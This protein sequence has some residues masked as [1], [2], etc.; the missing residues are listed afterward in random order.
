MGYQMSKELL[1][2]VLDG[3]KTQTRRPFKDGDH[4]RD[5]ECS[6]VYRSGRKLWAVGSRYAIQ[7]GRGKKGVAYI[8]VTKLRYDGDVRAISAED[9]RAEGF[10]TPLDFVAKWVSMYDK[11]VILEKLD[12]GRWSLLI[13]NQGKQVKGPHVTVNIKQV[14]VEVVAKADQI[15]ELIKRHR[16]EK[17][18]R[19]WVSEFKLVTEVA[20]VQS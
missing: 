5:T 6:A 15:L 1:P 12:K 11:N 16:P 13:S 7:P 4:V 17:K 2:L 9:A 14:T 3:T 18:Y 20:E 8:E 19:A 10:E